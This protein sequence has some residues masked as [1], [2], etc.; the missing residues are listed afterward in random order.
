MQKIS[1][2]LLLLMTGASCV[3]T[4]AANGV[5]A[6]QSLSNIAYGKDPLQNFDAWLPAGRTTDSTKV[7]V[8]IHGGGWAIGDK[9]DF[10]SQ[11]EGLK[12]FFPGYA[13]FFVNYRLATANANQFPAQEDDISALVQYI[14]DHCAQ[15]QISKKW[16]YLGGSAGAHLALLQAY[17]HPAPIKPLAVVSFYAPTDLTDLYN[18]PP[19]AYTV[20]LLQYAIGT[21]PSV[22]PNLYVQSSPLHFVNNQCSATILL[23]GGKDTLVSP[24]QAYALQSALNANNVS[25]QLVFYPNEGHGWTGTSFNDSLEK[26]KAFLALYAK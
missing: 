18:H 8:L 21:S 23:Q 17:K 14:Y 13:F 2:I 24:S 4:P 12:I 25:N 19:S 6:E 16:V 10:S 5:L 15:Y 9:S 20:Q 1:F 22:N 11:L 3:K 7:M 26:I